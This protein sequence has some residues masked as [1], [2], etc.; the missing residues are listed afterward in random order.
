MAASDGFAV[1][2][3]YQLPRRVGRKRLNIDLKKISKIN[4][5]RLTSILSLSEAMNM[6]KTTLHRHLKEGKIRPHKNA[7]KPYL[8]EDNKKTQLQFCLSMLEPCS[9]GS[10]P[11]FKNMYNYVHIDEKSFYLSK[12]SERYY[13]LPEENEP[14]RTC[15]SKQFITKV[16]FLVA[17]A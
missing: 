1:A 3:Y 14:L 16:M 6:A 5:R 13:L 10:Q 7:L 17:V 12:E 11:N 9:L 4:L 2:V 15:K 8:S